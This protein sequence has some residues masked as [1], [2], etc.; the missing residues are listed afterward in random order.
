MKHVFHVVL[1]IAIGVLVASTAISGEFFFDTVMD[2][3]I[4]DSTPAKVV[5]LQGYKEYALQ[6]RFNGTPNQSFDFEINN[7]NLR[8]VR[9]TVQL[10]AQGWANFNKV[11]PVYSPN[12]GV[13]IYH[14]PA[15]T[16]VKMT[17]YAGH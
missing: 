12:I 11:Y 3:T 13:V 14:P 2:K 9:E 16:K 15:N 10:N 17:I 7:N 5:N 6:A 8:V 1:V 4:S